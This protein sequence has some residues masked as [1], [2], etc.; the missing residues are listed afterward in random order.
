M[1]MTGI[2]TTE[3]LYFRFN[4]VEILSDITF[5]LEKGEFLGIVGP[6]GSGKTTLIRLLLG[7][8]RP[9]AGSATLF[10]YN[11]G[12]FNEWQRVGYLPQ[13]IAAFNPHFPATVE[14]IVALG[15]LAGK[16]FPRRAARGDRRSV[17]DAMALMDIT[18]IRNKLIGE[19][20]GGQQQRVLIAKALVAGPE[21]LIL[22]EPTTALDPEGRERFFATLKDLNEHG[23]V[24]I[25]M[26]THDMGTIG[27]HAS[28]LLYLD[29]NLIFYGG[30]NDFCLSR[31]MTN[32]FGEYSQ[33]LICHRHD[34]Q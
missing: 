5:T 7:L 12:L 32:Y 24:T 19:L 4:G 1:Q 9:T 16:S 2:V 10:G 27:Q 15:L 11:A 33:H 18:P 25:I 8:L 31:D 21:L 14:E 3:K 22:D 17:D 28:R 29:K 34:N 20:S 26:I 6:N 23:A 13:K 30:F